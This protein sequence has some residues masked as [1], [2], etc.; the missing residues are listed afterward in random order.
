MLAKAMSDLARYQQEQAPLVKNTKLIFIIA[1]EAR[2]YKYFA[3]N[4]SETDHKRRAR[5][6]F[7]P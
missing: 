5:S 1:S 4:S 2:S 6:G 7:F 3:A